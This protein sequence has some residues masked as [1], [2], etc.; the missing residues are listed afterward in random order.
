[1]DGANLLN[2]STQCSEVYESVTKTNNKIPM[3]SGSLPKA[4]NMG[5]L[6]ETERSENNEGK[7]KG[8]EIEGSG[9]D[10]EDDTYVDEDEEEDDD[11]ENGGSG[12]YV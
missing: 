4:K 12:E 8:E 6:E 2:V 3:N 10:E 11:E 1:M 9:E 5:P 7:G